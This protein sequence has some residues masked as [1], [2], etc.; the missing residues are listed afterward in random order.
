[1]RV[2]MVVLV[3]MR[4]VHARDFHIGRPAVQAVGE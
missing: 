2:R 4:V 3:R 1:M